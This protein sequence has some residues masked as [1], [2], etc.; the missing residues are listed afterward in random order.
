MVD[1]K[2]AFVFPSSMQDQSHANLNKD[3]RSFIFQSSESKAF[4]QYRHH[5]K[6]APPSPLVIFPPAPTLSHL[7]LVFTSSLSHVKAGEYFIDVLM[8]HSVENVAQLLASDERRKAGGSQ[9]ITY[10]GVTNPL[11]SINPQPA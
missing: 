3:K 11:W 7:R 8:E 9:T 1:G 2:L 4:S 10:S 5:H 6:H